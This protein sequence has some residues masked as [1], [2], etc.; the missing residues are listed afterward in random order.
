HIAPYIQPLAFYTGFVQI[1]IY[2]ARRHHFANG[3][4]LIVGKIVVIM[5]FILNDPVDLDEGIGNFIKY[6]VRSLEKLFQNGKVI[7]FYVIKNNLYVT[8]PFNI[9][10]CKFF[11]GIGS[12]AH[13]RHH[14]EQLLPIIFFNDIGKV[15]YAV[16]IFYRCPSEF[17]NKHYLIYCETTVFGRRSDLIFM[18][19]IAAGFNFIPQ[20]LRAGLLTKTHSASR[21]QPKLR[22]FC[23]NLWLVHSSRALAKPSR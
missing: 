8:L 13:C 17:K 21:L 7:L 2:Y 4:Y 18:A 5:R 15:N 19:Q 6:W 1:S 14:D 10:F 20:F 11:K 23:K 12:F 3:N 9:G 22:T 16:G